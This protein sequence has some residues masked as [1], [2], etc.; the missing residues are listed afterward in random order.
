MHVCAAYWMVLW[1]HI[2]SLFAHL[3]SVPHLGAYLHFLTDFAYTQPEDEYTLVTYEVVE[4][5]VCVLCLNH[6]SLILRQ[7]TL[8][9]L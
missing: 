3:C 2:F 7:P 9:Q 6:I 5:C 4:T 1:E 8:H